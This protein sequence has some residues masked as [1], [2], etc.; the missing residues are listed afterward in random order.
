MKDKIL[1]NYYFHFKIN[2]IK[3]TNFM[4]GSYLLFLFAVLTPVFFYDASY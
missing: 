4:V 1:K 2:F 3:N